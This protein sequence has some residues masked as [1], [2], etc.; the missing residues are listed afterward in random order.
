MSSNSSASSSVS[1]SAGSSMASQESALKQEPVA[2]DVVAGVA[3][4]NLHPALN[5]PTQQQQRDAAPGDGAVDDY[6]HGFWDNVFDENSSA[7][8][9]MDED[10]GECKRDPDEL[11]AQQAKDAMD[12]TSTSALL[13]DQWGQY[14]DP[15]TDFASSSMA[16]MNNP[17]SAST[18]GSGIMYYPSS[19][20]LPSLFDEYCLESIHDRDRVL[21]D[22]HALSCRALQPPVDPGP[23]APG[24]SADTKTTQRLVC[25]AVS[26]PPR[27]Q[28]LE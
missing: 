25:R 24:F 23:P 5:A 20:H 16:F 8:D 6:E 10:C 18:P 26:T 19:S 14:D 21:P 2:E 1:S 28:S 4:T 7:H 3:A 27:R 12:S 13:D 17:S 9:L 22:S 15:L 11:M